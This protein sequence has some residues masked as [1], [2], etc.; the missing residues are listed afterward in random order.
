MSTSAFADSTSDAIKTLQQQIEAQQAQINQQQ[1][2]LE[3]LK[4]Q[5]RTAEAQADKANAAAMAA[6]TQATQAAQA[7]APAAN[8]ML[9]H[10]ILYKSSAVTLTANGF[11]E[12]AS[13]DRDHNEE[14]DVGSSYSLASNGIPLPISELYHSGEFRESARQSRLALLA[15]GNDDY[16]KLSAYYEGDFLGAAT[17]A[18]SKESNSYTPRI[19]H[20]YMSYDDNQDGWHLLAGQT[21]SLLTQN[22]VGIEP[23]NENIPLTIDAQYVVGFNWTRNPQLR[24]VKDFGNEVHFGIS[25]ESPQATCYNGGTSGMY[26]SDNTASAVPGTVA[27]TQCTASGGSLLSGVTASIDQAPDVIAKLAVDPGWGHYELYGLARFFHDRS[28]TNGIAGSTAAMSNNDTFGGGIGAGAILPVMPKMLDLQ[29]NTLVGKG[30]GRYG[31]AQF[32]DTVVNANNGA[33]DPIPMVQAMVGA[34]AHPTTSVDAYLYG[35]LEE[36]F[37]TDVISNG[38]NPNVNYGYG[39]ANYI[40]T[41]CTTELAASNATQACTANFQEAWQIQPGFWWKWYQG[42]AGMMETGAS[43]SYTKATAF[44]GVGGTPSTAE[45]IFMVSFRYYPF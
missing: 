24:L 9:S 37:K 10:G 12:A 35:G 23:R 36:A 41:N 17:T 43:Y 16:K 31:S 26:A 21:W 1:Q 39:N 45:N 30:I 4:A 28:Q 19:R 13:F 32:S 5:A 40:N 6:Q 20:V 29:F 33:M 11:I 3:L 44:A 2:Q 15:Q 22:K 8:G 27:N 14:A 18:N 25:A 34:V 7:T 42:K 38:A